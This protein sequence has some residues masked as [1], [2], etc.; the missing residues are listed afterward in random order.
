M[1]GKRLL[2]LF[3]VIFYPSYRAGSGGSGKDICITGL[4]LN[5]FAYALYKRAILSEIEKYIAYQ[6]E[7]GAKILN[8]LAKEEQ[9]QLLLLLGKI[10]ANVM[11]VSLP[12][13]L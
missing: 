1:Q 12:K 8:G 3:V 2:L 10:S 6:S 7:M 11:Q 9:E 13:G 4:S 5:V